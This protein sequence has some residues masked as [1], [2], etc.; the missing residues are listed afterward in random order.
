MGL[1]H[2]EV[3]EKHLDFFEDEEEVITPFLSG[4]D[5]TWARSRKAYNTDL[6][7]YF[8]KPEK[9]ISEAYG[10]SR[11]VMLVYS[12][13]P[14]MES[15]TIQAAELFI[16]DSPAKGRV[17]NL[18][19]I[20]VS[21]D[22]DVE[23]WISTYTAEN[24]ESRIIIPFS[25]KKLREN[26]SN[27]H[28]IRRTISRFFYERDLF[29]YRLPLKN[30]Y[31]FF[32]RKD[33]VASLYDSIKKGENSGLFGL[34]K[35]GKTSILYKLERQIHES[36]LA[37][38]LYF[39][40]KVPSIRKLRWYQLLEK[41]SNKISSELDLPIEGEFNEIDASESFTKLIERTKGVKKIVLVFDEIEYIS[42][43]AIE[44]THWKR[45]FI[46]F[47]QTLWGTQS[48][49]R[50]ITA[51]IVGVNPHP[52]E[53]DT[54][55]RVQNPL[56]GIVPYSYLRGL[57][58]D[59]M[60]SM[61]KIL[62]KRMGLHFEPDAIEYLHERYGG[63]P[64]LTRIACSLINNI[65]N[66]LNYPKPAKVSSDNLKEY[67]E[68]LDSNLMHYYRHVVSELRE[69]YPQEYELLEWLASGQKA[70]FNEE[71]K[72]R[73]HI[74]HLTGYGLLSFDEGGT[75]H[76]SI[77]AVGRYIGLEY[78]SKEGRK[79]I[80]KTVDAKDRPLWL[81]N[82]KKSI[83]TDLRQ[84]EALIQKKKLPP[85]FGPNS[86]PEADE[87]IG[88]EVVTDKV[89]YGHFI[90]TCNRCFVESIDRYGKS[91]GKKDY[92]WEDIKESY[93]ALWD[94]LYRIRLYRHA[95]A[96]RELNEKPHEDFNK[97]IK[98]DLEG[99]K[100]SQVRELNFVIQQ[101]VLESLLNSIQV[102]TYSL[103][104]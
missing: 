16:T 52:L 34:R 18:N 29:D 13:Y 5:I 42:P 96:H 26:K 3:R 12:P 37:S 68:S 33:V 90:N 55:E 51:I 74:R 25:V 94:A 64:Y 84:L 85:L 83:V 8:L 56:F 19:Y 82:S 41:I 48:I 73:E 65:V 80:F 38:V 22:E 46:S 14:Q 20:L 27:G 98:R 87:F 59:D 21:G 53:I 4:F 30:D 15:R 57:D 9:H 43:I 61:I 49:N 58:F 45:D 78:M 77:P 72:Y 28:F 39:D 2:P 7:V 36:D 10:F 70:K 40:C 95:Y 67:E 17:E 88:V 92:F 62:G 104:K 91:I 47:W 11:E 1:I 66:S 102:E 75:P 103:S 69:F 60:K 50:I 6:S 93:P 101:C 100:P 54:V 89:T 35:T 44:D 79:T 32:G 24:P 31:Y 23:G 97:Y 81:I 86:F 71:A 63:H 76:I 99:Q